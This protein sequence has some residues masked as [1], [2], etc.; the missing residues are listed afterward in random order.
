M[1]DANG[2]EKINEFTKKKTKIQPIKIVLFCFA[3]IEKSNN[4]LNY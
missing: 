2:G 4:V 3:A 1:I